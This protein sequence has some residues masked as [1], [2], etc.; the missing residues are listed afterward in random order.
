MLGEDS[1]FLLIHHP[2]K[3]DIERQSVP[4]SARIPNFDVLSE[5]VRAWD[6]DPICLGGDRNPQGPSPCG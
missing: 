6:A 1:L 4:D 2:G 3:L 5:M